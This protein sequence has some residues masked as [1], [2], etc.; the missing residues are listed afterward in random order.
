MVGWNRLAAHVQ[1]IRADMERGGRKVF[2][3]GNGYQYCALMA[4]YLPDHPPTYDMYLH[5]RLTMYAAHVERLKLHL[6]E[7]ANFI[8]D[9]RANNMALFCLPRSA[10]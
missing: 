2:I 1:D 6:G 8:N 9:G 3:A 5:Y 4:F 7:D 10:C